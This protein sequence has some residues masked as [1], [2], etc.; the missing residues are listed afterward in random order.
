MAAEMSAQDYDSFW[1][2][3]RKHSQSK[4]CLSDIVDVAVGAQN[5]ADMWGQHYKTSAFIL[6]LEL[7]ESNDS[8]TKFLWEI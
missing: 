7:L 3:I 2:T 4:C 1:D 6:E 8:Y 5:I